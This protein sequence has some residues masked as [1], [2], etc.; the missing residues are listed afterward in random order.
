MSAISLSIPPQDSTTGE[1]EN[2]A[3]E[4]S[5]NT[6][7][8]YRISTPQE[9]AVQK[10]LLPANLNVRTQV[11]TPQGLSISANS[12]YAYAI[13]PIA[14]ALFWGKG[15]REIAESKPLS[16]I[17]KIL[18]LCINTTS[19]YNYSAR[20]NGQ[21][22]SPDTMI[23]APVPLAPLDAFSVDKVGPV[24]R[25]ACG[26]APKSFLLVSLR[27]SSSDAQIPQNDLGG[28]RWG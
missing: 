6:H 27:I 12:E 14:L 23:K 19:I 15:G 21:W 7:A 8:G 2:V 16:M 26:S 11:W 22:F 13:P 28:R 20:G 1:P 17:S 25:L 9:N 3:V 10:S 4:L 24:P 18:T 5:A